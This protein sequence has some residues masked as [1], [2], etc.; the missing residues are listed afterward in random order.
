MDPTLAGKTPGAT[1]T[2][3]D[4]LPR[5]AHHR[6]AH[7]ESFFHDILLDDMDLFNLDVP[8]LAIDS[9]SSYG[10]DCEP[11]RSKQVGPTGSSSTHFRS[12]SV[13]DDFFDC[14][15]LNQQSGLGDGVS[16][17]SFEHDKKC[18]GVDE[19]AQLSLVD[20]K[21]AKRIL[22]NRQSAARS[23]ERKVRYTSELERKVQ[24][25]QSEAT[26]LS[27]QVTMM[28]RDTSGMTIE[29][30]ELMLRLQALE[31]QAQLRDALNETL[32]EE[33]NRLKI[34]TG[35]VPP[36]N[37]NSYNQALPPQFSSHPQMY[38][39]FINHQGYQAQQQQP[40]RIPPSA[41]NYD[42][43]RHGQPQASFPNYDQRV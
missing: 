32:R 10:P 18:V 41:I 42:E 11:K 40:T 26:T 20:P 43:A 39:N 21:R 9:D 25:L 16:T 27:A 7:S 4:P 3:P 36:L 31:Q 33:V 23:K 22:A 30:K 1:Q 14:E 5:M 37:G 8:S 24:T 17:T 12:L 28:Q 29:N 13:D 2:T 15:T 38:N 6:R 19:M 35:Q 34:E